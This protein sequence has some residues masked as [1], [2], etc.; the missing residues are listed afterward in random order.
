M[1]IFELLIVL[2]IGAISLG[3]VGVLLAA[4]VKILRRKD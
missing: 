2:V 1:G 4:A 3:I